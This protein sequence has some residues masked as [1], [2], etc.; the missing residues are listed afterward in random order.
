M[1]L[2]NIKIHDFKTHGIQLNGFDGVTMKNI[3]VGPNRNTDRL[4]PYYAHM[5]ALL[6]TYRIMLDR[7]EVAR[8]TCVSFTGQRYADRECVTLQELVD[9][10]Q[11]ALDMA[12][13]QALGIKN[14][15]HIAESVTTAELEEDADLERKLSIWA[16]SGSALM[17]DHHSTQTA[18]LYGIFMNYIGSN[19]IGWYAGSETSKSHNLVMENVKIHD[20]HHDTFEN[21]AF[22]RGS[23]TAGQRILNCLNAPFNAYHVYGDD[24]VD[25][26]SECNNWADGNE[27]RNFIALDSSLLPFTEYLLSPDK[28]QLFRAEGLEYV[29]N[30]ISDIQLLSFELINKHELSWNYCAG[31]AADLA[32]L[33]EFAVRGTQF[34]EGTP[35]LVGTHDP[36]IHPGSVLTT[37]P[38]THSLSLSLS[39]YVTSCVLRK[40]SDGTAAQR[41]GQCGFTRCPN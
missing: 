39:S 17:N 14:W 21:I 16:D 23:D 1:L 35:L 34:P 33:T 7:E 38:F 28:C 41:S 10:V 20:L 2:D 25:A 29:G 26:I 24:A 3:D 40:G 32:S 37:T 36:M 9:D 12:F 13:E 4:S 6:P 5:K 22:S 15:D 27:K 19:V 30:L 11:T 31:G 18:T 8:Q